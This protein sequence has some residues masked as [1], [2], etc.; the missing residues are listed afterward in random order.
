MLIVSCFVAW[1][2]RLR[3]EVEVNSALYVFAGGGASLIYA[4]L[5][6]SDKIYEVNTLARPVT[7]LYA[8]V[9]TALMTFGLLLLFAFSLKLTASYSR[10]WGFSWAAL[11]VGSLVLTRFLLAKYYWYLHDKGNLVENYLI[12]GSGDLC[13][14][15]TQELV[16]SADPCINVVGIFD[17]GLNA[18]KS[19]KL[20][21]V[22]LIS[23]ANL[24]EIVLSENVDKI[25]VAESFSMESSHDHLIKLASRW[26][27]DVLVASDFEGLPVTEIGYRRIEQR[28][29][30]QVA[31]K[32]ISGWQAFIKALE[33]KLLAA[34]AVMAFSPLLLLTAIAIKIES[35]GPI[36]FTQKR[37]G[38]NG[39]LIKVYKFRSMYFD[40]LDKDAASLAIKGDSRI[41]KVGRF[42]RK[43]SIDELPQL[44][45]VLVG[46]MSL[47]G[48]RP[49]AQKAKA[50]GKL[51]TDAVD[52]Y[53]SRHRVKPGITGWAQ[54]NGWRGETDTLA[55][56]EK[57]VEHDIYYINNWSIYLD[58][59]ILV[60][61]CYVLLFKTEEAY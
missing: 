29:Y 35:R 33:D 31:V 17:L 44:F 37:Y 25:I 38:F 52:E 15:L 28:F 39:E 26:A 16:E 12:L 45:N 14:N 41:T 10:I 24:G 50:A 42:I 18:L 49:H 34:C 61:T 11:F 51:Y 8:A 54:V 21:E 7:G 32:P 13:K 30:F 19:S 3:L 53:A 1:L 22:S 57:R 27:V 55:K 40:Q 60:K 58:I 5:A 46:N 20:G 36:L 2:L 23:G 56:I 9:K 48:P 6:F 47:V 59:F 4:Y 43:T